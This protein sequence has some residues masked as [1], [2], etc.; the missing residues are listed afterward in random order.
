MVQGVYGDCR[1]RGSSKRPIIKR[2]EEGEGKRR[3]K[4][5][6][7]GGGFRSEWKEDAKVRMRGKEGC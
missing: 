3:K 2:K 5:M 4:G 7:K 1:G 6:V